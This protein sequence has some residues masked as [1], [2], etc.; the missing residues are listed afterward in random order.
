[1]TQ[2]HLMGG[3]SIIVFSGLMLFITISTIKKRFPSTAIHPFNS[4]AEIM[5]Y[6]QSSISVLFN[7]VWI[8][9]LPLGFVLS[10]Y[11]IKIPIFLYQRPEI[12]TSSATISDLARMFSGKLS[13][14]SAV[15]S[16][17]HTPGML[18]YGYNSSI[19]KSVLFWGFFLICAITFKA[20]SNKLQQFASASNMKNVFYFKKI[21]KSSLA[22]LILFFP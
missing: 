4:A 3:L 8:L 18:D 12:S 5:S 6:Y 7:Q 16:L 20:V 10:E 11:I 15:I 19:S 1:M 9:L 17:L 2:E 13:L 21:L 22:I 14:K